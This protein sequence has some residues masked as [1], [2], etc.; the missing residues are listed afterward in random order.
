MWEVNYLLYHSYS[1]CVITVVSCKKYSSHVTKWTNQGISCFAVIG[2]LQSGASIHISLSLACPFTNEPTKE[3]RICNYWYSILT[4]VFIIVIH[5]ILIVIVLSLA[6][7]LTNIKVVFLLLLS[8]T[9]QDITCWLLGLQFDARIQII[10]CS[11]RSH[12][13]NH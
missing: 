4:L 6:C 12:I 2:T 9:N 5:V 1:H 7:S 10:R 11:F 3:S 8:W 13:D